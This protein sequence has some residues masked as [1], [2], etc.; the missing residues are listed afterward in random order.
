[1]SAPSGRNEAAGRVYE[2]NY[3]GKVVYISST[4]RMLQYGVPL[5]GLGTFATMIYL[6]RRRRTRD[7]NKKWPPDTPES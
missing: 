6:E 3:R 7:K 1:M 2:Y 5:F 4:E